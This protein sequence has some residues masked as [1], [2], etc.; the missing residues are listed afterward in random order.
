MGVAKLKSVGFAVGLLG[1][2]GLGFAASYV[3]ERDPP[4]G[5]VLFVEMDISP[6]FVEAEYLKVATHAEVQRGYLTALKNLPSAVEARAKKGLGP[7]SLS[8]L[9]DD[10]FAASIVRGGTG[11]EGMTIVD[12]PGIID[13]TREDLVRYLSE[14][15]ATHEFQPI[16]VEQVTLTPISNQFIAPWQ[17]GLIFSAAGGFIYTLIFLLF[18]GLRPYLKRDSPENN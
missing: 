12:Q 17:I 7:D 8:R 4:D 11:L 13:P 2:I 3:V 9:S 15:I 5:R 6:E 1:S 14:L 16:S 18:Q 10:D